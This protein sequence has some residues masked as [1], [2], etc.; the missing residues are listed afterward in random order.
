MSDRTPPWL[1]DEHKFAI[2]KIY[3]ECRE[4]TQRTGIPHHVDHII[5]LRGKLVSG[6]H[7]PW[8]LQIITAKENLSKGNRV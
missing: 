7:V 4:V 3:E 8:N 2:I 5:P 1:T 6:L